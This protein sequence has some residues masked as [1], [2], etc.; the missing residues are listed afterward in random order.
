MHIDYIS[1][2]IS[3]ADGLDYTWVT[4]SDESYVSEE[5]D[6]TPSDDIICNEIMNGLEAVVN[7][8]CDYKN[9]TPPL[10]GRYVKIIRKEVY[11]R[12]LLHFCEVEVMSCPRGRWGY[13]SSNSD[14]CS[15][16]CDRC[17]D[18]NETCR[19]SDGHCF[20]GCQD[21]FWGGSC[22]QAC[23][24]VDDAPCRVSDGYCVTRCK[25]GFWGGTCK[26]CNCA[27]D[28]PCRKSDG[29]CLEGCKNGFWGGICDEQCTDGVACNQT[30]GLCPSRKYEL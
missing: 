22:N 20:T 14:D 13:D 6:T 9:R 28:A 29:Y 24:C 5:D 12:H 11:D 1:F 18:V 2:D 15:Q 16:V 7:V 25:D 21:G 19:V 4:V 30:D 10:R 26:R 23:N 17:Q 8:T 27:D 3:I